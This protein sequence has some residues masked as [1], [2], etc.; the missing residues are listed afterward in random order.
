MFKPPDVK[1]DMYNS[2]KQPNLKGES[3]VTKSAGQ[4]KPFQVKCW[5]CA[6]DHY[7]N[8]CPKTR[9]KDATMYNVHESSIVGDFSR[10]IPR[11]YAALDNRQEYH[12]YTIIYL[13]GK[14]KNK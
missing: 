4:K 8:K 11:I 12:L 6:G 7:L 9:S 2:F 13:E 3:R 1:H 10:I 14:L 5:K